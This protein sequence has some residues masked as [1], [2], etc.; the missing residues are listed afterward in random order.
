[1]NTTFE[2]VLSH[3]EATSLLRSLSLSI[4]K[5][6]LGQGLGPIIL[7]P[8]T[9]PCPGHGSVHCNFTIRVSSQDVPE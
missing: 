7:G 3:L 8:T 6:Q 4:N 2:F 1:M 9:G 5:P